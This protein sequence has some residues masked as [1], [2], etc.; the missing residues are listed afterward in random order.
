M[1]EHAEKM[2]RYYTENC[3]MVVVMGEVAS[4]LGGCGGTDRQW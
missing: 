2:D 3:I 1:N 4:K